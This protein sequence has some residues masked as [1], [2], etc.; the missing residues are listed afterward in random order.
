MVPALHK[1][2]ETLIK[3]A[4]IDELTDQGHVMTGSLLKSIQI[5]STTISN[6]LIM[7][8]SFFAYGRILENGV[9]AANIPYGTSSGKK[10]SKYIQGL[11]EFVKLR[12][13]E[14]DN[15]KALGV[16]F[17][18]AKTHKKEGMPTKNAFSATFTKNGRRLGWLEFALLGAENAILEKLDKIFGDS[19]EGSI[20]NLIK[21]I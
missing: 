12:R 18:I 1:E 7:E 17:A 19:F 10:T 11:V 16:A 14:T 15:K 3:G 21:K 5:R 8:G 20:Q 9:T 4:M 6:K 13:I 2:L